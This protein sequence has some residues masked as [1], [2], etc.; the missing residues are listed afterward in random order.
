[1]A[2]ARPLF[3]NK[4]LPHGKKTDWNRDPA[5]ISGSDILKER[6]L[7]PGKLDG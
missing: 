3:W 4:A 1:M 5:V 2:L 7:C 6:G